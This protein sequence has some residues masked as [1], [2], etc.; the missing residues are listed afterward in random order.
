MKILLAVAILIWVIVLYPHFRIICKRLLL[1]NK[2]KSLCRR[3]GYTFLPT[4]SFPFLGQKN[5]KRYDFSIETE[6]EVLCV[7]LFA[8]KHKHSVLKFHDQNRMYSFTSGLW[9]FGRWGT[10]LHMPF[11]EKLRPLPDTDFFDIYIPTASTKQQT[12]ILLI[13]PKCFEIHGCAS[14]GTGRVLAVGD[15]LRGMRLESGKTFLEYL[16]KQ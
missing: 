12:K 13:H 7:K 11:N 15:S 10:V 2:I 14:D 9:L 16:S 1:K 5:G 8:A 6:T 3:R 4:H